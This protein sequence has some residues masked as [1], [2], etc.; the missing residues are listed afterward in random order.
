M[1]KQTN[2]KSIEIIQ[3]LLYQLVGSDGAVP[4]VIALELFADF[5]W[6]RFRAV[7]FHQTRAAGTAV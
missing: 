4:E 1:N 3:S 2:K 7:L 6:S 5:R